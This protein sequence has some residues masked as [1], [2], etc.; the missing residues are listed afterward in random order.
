MQLAMAE[1]AIEAVAGAA[2]AAF[3]RWPHHRYAPLKSEPMSSAR[4]IPF[5]RAIARYRAVWYGVGCLCLSFRPIVKLYNTP[6]RQHLPI[7]Y[8]RD[9]SRQLLL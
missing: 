4:N 7:L 3:A 1:T 5:R 8:T 9:S 6:D 2:S